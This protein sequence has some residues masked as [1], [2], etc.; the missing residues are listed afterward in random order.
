[1]LLILLASIAVP[2][3]RALL[4]VASETLTRGTVQTELKR[5]VPADAIV[6][7][8]VSLGKDDIAIHLISTRGIPDSKVTEL[9]QDLMR[10]TGR[11]VQLTV[12]AVA[13]RN[14]LAGLMERL[15]RPAPE[16]PK[17][18]TLGE[19]QKELLDRVQP[20]LQ[21]IWPS[22]DAPI[23]DFDVVLGTAGIAIDV[24]Y[25][26]AK[27]LGKVPIG[28]V[29]HSLQTKL[30]IPDLTLKA[31]RVRPSRVPVKKAPGKP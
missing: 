8:Q 31:E 23:Q 17:E 1:M 16:I 10:R 13:S 11:N 25:Q 29:L 4:Q 22:P 2:L 24:R 19:M 21:E 15:D 5:F 27:E 12:D 30:G 6:S 28:M 14:E 18:R 7:Q 26:A 20:A 9:R 3:R